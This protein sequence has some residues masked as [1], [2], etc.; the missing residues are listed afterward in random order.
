MCAELPLIVAFDIAASPE[1]N[2]FLRPQKSRWPSDIQTVRLAHPSDS[3]ASCF[4]SFAGLAM[5]YKLFFD[6]SYNFC[7]FTHSTR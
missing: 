5:P 7:F 4:A 6:P 2:R 1:K 3:W